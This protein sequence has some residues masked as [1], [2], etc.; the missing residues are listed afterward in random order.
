MSLST[1]L[2]MILEG[3][4][5]LGMAGSVFVLLLTGIEDVETLLDRKEDVPH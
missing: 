2:V 5:A 4:F 1:I 3:M